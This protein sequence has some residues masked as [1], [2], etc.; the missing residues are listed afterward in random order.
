MEFFYR[1]F[2]V[3]NII[4]FENL[5]E[6]VGDLTIANAVLLGDNVAEPLK[7]IFAIVN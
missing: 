5:P 4:V 3:T 1:Y 2:I 7:R 6:S